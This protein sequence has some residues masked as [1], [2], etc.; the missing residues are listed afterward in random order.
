VITVI[1]PAMAQFSLA[2]PPEGSEPEL[3]K[4]VINCL[5]LAEGLERSGNF[6]VLT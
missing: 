2:C 5:A 3:A 1:G 6:T 4:S